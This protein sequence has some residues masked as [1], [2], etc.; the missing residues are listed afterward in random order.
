MRFQRIYSMKNTR[1]F[2]KG[3]ARIFCLAAL[4]AFAI[5]P[6]AGDGIQEGPNVPPRLPP[7]MDRVPDSNQANAINAQEARR[8]NFDAINAERKK[9]ITNDSEKLLKLAT[10]LKIEVDKTGKDELSILVIRK[11]EEIEKLAHGVKE[12]MQLTVGG[13]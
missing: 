12:K 11:A 5:T 3:L 13:S 10:D 7:S 4:A 2:Q 9:Q 6:V 8:R 1:F